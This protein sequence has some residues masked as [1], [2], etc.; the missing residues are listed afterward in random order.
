MDE[1]LVRGVVRIL[2]ADGSTAGTGFLI[3]ADG[4]IVTCAHVL[5]G[6][7]AVSLVF[8][9]TS[10]ARLAR[11][12]PGG[13]RASN[14]E[15]V[16]ILRL[17]GASPAGA[18][19]LRLGAS[20]QSLGHAV[21]C[22]G[23]PAAALIAGMW[24]SGR[25][26]G[27]TR[28]DG[29]PVL[30]LEEGSDITRGFS[31][32]PVIDLLSR[33][34]IG[35]VSA[36]TAADA[37]G[38]QSGAVFATPLETLQE[39]VP[40]L[41]LVPALAG[42][43]FLA[44]MEGD[45]LPPL[46][47]R[48]DRQSALWLRENTDS[49]RY[50]PAVFAARPAMQAAIADFLDGGCAGFVL[51]GESGMGKT[52]L[53]CHLIEQWRREGEL[54]LAFHAQSLQV[55]QPLE[56]RILLDLHLPAD[57]A[58]LLQVLQTARRR[59][60]LVLDGV[61]EHAQ[62]IQLLQ[63]ISSFVRR[64]ANP[65]D[66][67]GPAA[68]KLLLSFRSR[69]LD[70]LLDGLPGGEQD[71]ARLF[72][73][74]AF[75]R[76]A[77][78]EG[79]DDARSRYRFELGAIAPAEIEAIYG[80]YRQYHAAP[81]APARH[82]PITTFADIEKSWYP[83]LANPFYL[84]MLVEAYNGRAIPVQPWHGEIMRSFCELK[85]W[86]SEREA[87]R[88]ATRAELV[89]QLVAQ[90]RRQ[91]LAIL[92]KD[93]LE[94]LSPQWA[95]AVHTEGV[96]ASAYR[97]LIEDGVLMET[98]VRE[99]TGRAARTQ[100]L[101]RFA[102]DTLFEYLLGDDI[103]REAGGWAGLSGARLGAEIRQGQAFPY[104]VGAVEHLVLEAVDSGNFLPL[105]EL[106]G[107]LD[108]GVHEEV[109]TALSPHFQAIAGPSGGWYLTYD[110]TGSPELFARLEE[111]RFLLRILWKLYEWGDPVSAPLSTLAG[112]GRGRGR[113][114]R[115]HRHFQ[116]LVEAIEC[117]AEPR[118][119]FNIALWM[120]GRAGLEKD[121]QLTP[122]T[123][124]LADRLR[125]RRIDVGEE[126]N[127]ADERAAVMAIQALAL[128]DTGDLDAAI[129]MAEQASLRLQALPQ[130]DFDGQRAELHVQLASFHGRAGQLAETV[131]H[132]RRAAQ[133]L[134]QRPRPDLRERQLLVNALGFERQALEGQDASADV[135]ALLAER[136]GLLRDLLVSDDLPAL[137][138]PLA[139]DLMALS[140]AAADAGDPQHSLACASEAVELCR[141]PAAT[142]ED[143]EESVPPLDTLPAALMCQGLAH[144]RLDELDG[145]YQAFGEAIDIWVRGA[146]HGDRD[147]AAMSL[148]A[149]KDR[150]KLCSG[151]ERWDLVA[152]DLLLAFQIYIEACGDQAPGERVIQR[153][154]HLLSW[155][156]SVPQ[157]QR[158]SV[159]E[160]LG[161]ENAALVRDFVSG[162]ASA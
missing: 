11:L 2:A 21:R 126:G 112:E 155:F 65:P 130:A 41:T 39:I 151:A 153:F 106:F 160:S 158:D 157:A 57:F 94:A 159:Y 80:A 16:A 135:R 156:G 70:R 59:L 117:G 43:T 124:G 89:D 107:A 132:A 84:R 150:C 73:D 31:G 102:F 123:S 13:L 50:L 111:S 17:E 120:A 90:M 72:P 137:R 10:E 101:V 136:V 49:G 58:A 69:F 67:D 24:G 118:A 114:S 14:A 56:A 29:H 52:S 77:G 116:R 25:I 148:Q 46:R 119:A 152:V 66:A 32:A 4:L 71:E 33:C 68:I 88:Y 47:E 131:V 125:T 83:L 23:Y 145:A 54:V 115:W 85:I 40:Q 144:Q 75:L 60:I 162:I 36:I 146:D 95:R 12:E 129:A 5:G 92:R 37:H 99:T 105:V 64:Y 6:R 86:G 127:R 98:T 97:Q 161:A 93:A 1:Q 147:A 91:Q 154:G 62:A 149:L 79:A 122:L 140:A 100:V 45:P 3:S 8:S 53:L 142:S 27:A 61:N 87:H 82:C 133:L 28:Q 139:D 26:V 78:S 121:H 143:P 22:F 128:A 9:D 44:G 55:E 30:Q 34:A 74:F 42:S 76:R 7:D 104:L 18:V 20:G 138:E 81:D 141:A 63:Q 51:T 48:A 96:A 19:P 109:Y 35:M 15:D 134:R 113:R 38:R 108:C 103:L 110:R